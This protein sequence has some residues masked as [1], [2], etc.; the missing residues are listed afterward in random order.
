MAPNLESIRSF[1]SNY[2]HVPGPAH[3]GR[4]V[5]ALLF[6]AVELMDFAVA[7]ELFHLANPAANQRQPGARP[8][9]PLQ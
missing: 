5:V 9:S 8:Q 6:P 1:E 4:P 2:G 3:R 7:A